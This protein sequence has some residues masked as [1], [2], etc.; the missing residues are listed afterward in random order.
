MLA[1]E[2]PSLTSIR[3]AHALLHARCHL[4][5]HGIHRAPGAATGRGV[6]LR[7]GGD[8]HAINGELN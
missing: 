2:R 5:G 7:R 4:G 8:R 6:A 1:N 3:D